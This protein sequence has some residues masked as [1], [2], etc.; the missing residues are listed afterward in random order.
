MWF[1]ANVNKLLL[2][3]TVI[4]ASALVFLVLYNLGPT[5]SSMGSSSTTNRFNPSTIFMRG[6]ESWLVLRCIY[7]TYGPSTAL[8]AL[9]N[10]FLVAYEQ[11][12]NNTYPVSQYYALVSTYPRCSINATQDEVSA[13]I[14][15]S[16][17]RVLSIAQSLGINPNNLGT[18]MFIIFNKGNNATYVIIGASSTIYNA[19]NYTARGIYNATVQ[20]AIG[21]KANPSQVSAILSLTRDALIFGNSTSDVLVIELLDTT[22]P[23]CAVF[24]ARLAGPLDS[25]I[26][27]GTVEFAVVYFPT[28]VLS[29]LS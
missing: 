23:F 12:N 18:P 17:Q 29:Y 24:Q 1:V 20:Y 11:L 19:I 3:I 14:Q 21:F 22:C 9:N 28:H 16:T 2:V 15:A 7:N 10:M 6:V 26:R 8:D 27:S 4:L 25:M 13:L 5:G